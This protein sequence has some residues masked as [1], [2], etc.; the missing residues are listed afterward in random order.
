MTDKFDSAFSYVLIYVF[1]IYDNKHKGCLK[2]GKATLKLDDESQYSSLLTPSSTLL[3]KAAKTRINGYTQT[4]GIDYQLI[5]TELAERKI[6]K[7]EGN[8]KQ[9]LLEYFDDHK[10]HDVL[11]NS[12]IKNVKFGGSKEW[13]RTDLDTVKNAIKAVKE[14][15]KTLTGSEVSTE[16]VHID[17]RPEQQEAIDMT[18]ARFKKGNKMLW[19]AKMRFGKTLCTLEVIRKEQFKKNLILTHRPV[20]DAGWHEDF[21]KIFWNSQYT[22]LSKGTDDSHIIHLIKADIPFVLFASIQDLRGSKKVGGKF[23]KNDILFDTDWDMVVIDE[24]HE[25]TKTSLGDNVLKD[26]IKEDSYGKTK[27]IYLSGTPFNLVND[28]DDD[29]V[30]TWDYVM[31]Q[32]AKSGWDIIHGLDW[33][34]YEGLP[35][36]GIFTYDIAKAI[37]G[38]EDIEDKAFNFR[39]FFRVWTGAVQNDGRLIPPESGVG[40]F[41]HEKDV[42]SFV[43]LLRLKN[44][45]SNYP[46]SKEEY[47]DYFRHSL[48]MLPGVKEASALETLLKEDEVFCNFQI[49]NVAGDTPTGEKSDALERLT[50]AISAHPEDT[51]TITLSC[52]RLTTGV[53][54][55]PWTVVLM[56]SGATSTSASMYLQTIFRVQSPANINGRIKDRCYAFDFAPDRTLQ[57]VAEAGKLGTRPGSNDSGSEAKMKEFLNFCPVIAINGSEMQK[58][59]VDSM[60]RQLKRYYAARVAQNGFDDIKLYND[61]LLKLTD[62]DKKKFEKLKK[63]VGESKAADIKRTIVI[64]ES[65]L[66]PE[67][68]EAAEQAAK[69]KRE[70]KELTEEEKEALRK[71]KEA[72]D[73]K[74]K[75]ISILRAISIRIPL[76]IY[77]MDNDIEE[78]I[79]IDK[80][81]SLVDEDSWNEFMPSGITKAIFDEFKEYYD[82]DIFIEAGNKIRRKVKAADELSPT[83]RVKKVAE[84]FSSFKNPDKETVLT[85]W[86]VVCMHLSDC[87]GGFDFYDEK[88][89]T[90]LDEPRFVY[91][92]D[93]TD[94]TFANTKAQILEINSKSGLYPLYATYSIFRKRLDSIKEESRDADKQFNLWNQTLIENIFVICK[95]EM[96]KQITK[97]TLLGYKNGKINAHHFDD[98]INQFRNKS[99]QVTLKIKNA[100]FWGN[101]GGNMKFD[102]V[103]GN[104]P[105]QAIDNGS[106]ASAGAIYPYFVLSSF[107]ISSQYVSMIMPSRWFVTGRGTDEFR[108]KM[109]N[110]R[111]IRRLVDFEDAKVCFQ[112]VDIKGGVCFFL[113]DKDTYGPC[114]ITS[115]KSDGKITESTRNLL[116]NGMNTFIR[117]NEMISIINKVKSCKE[118]AFDSIVSPRDPF[119]YDIREENSLKTVPHKYTHQKSC[120]DCV[121]FYYNGWRKEGIGYVPVSSINDNQNWVNLYKVLIP[122]S[123]GSGDTSRD[124]LK[125]IIAKPMSVCTETY[126]VVGPFINEEEC[127]NAI[128]YILTK[129]FQILV[130]V[131][132]IS[133]HATKRVYEM[134]PLQDF[135]KQWTDEMLYHKYGLTDEEIAYIESAI[136]PIK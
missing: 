49:V 7:V 106:G 99:E 4:A 105:Y 128:S 63:I 129:F 117:D 120:V 76:L 12:G 15:R 2:V 36:L 100:S 30:Y 108:R 90:L 21:V 97:R 28:F 8:K 33:N 93:V 107:E 66:G 70:K 130:S 46:F 45:A 127:K 109:L 35:K 54:V 111:Q 26:V 9:I 124:K 57:M 64:S 24:A 75:A 38:Y 96:A 122:N 14:G 123:W 136:K 115:H 82:K 94:N 116:E 32:K 91:R 103:V 92:G 102:A 52:G 125:P 112:G 71:L 58:Y 67:E 133:Q 88:H 11:K 56:L 101:S 29:E 89:E 43:H 16:H 31:E 61:K 44:E 72:R 53:T 69:K 23:D 55:K 34:P 74:S 47:R 41:V 81:S 85:P 114:L 17:F 42:K 3:N 6:E 18:I 134:V 51:R 87:L 98:I 5:Y 20:V 131:L 50:D 110:N 37:P 126:L 118:A 19:N 62:L 119:G 22:Y 73:A 65:G 95:T 40:R 39:E 48:W 121:E 13:F 59:D 1:A 60:L 86:R 80:F 83:E 113:W 135:S 10:V 27:Q 25:G 79:T 78:N 104:P 84:I 77:G 68:Q 132:K